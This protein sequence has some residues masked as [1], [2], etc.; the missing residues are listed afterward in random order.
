VLSHFRPL[1]WRLPGAIIW[2]LTP[3]A[4]FQTVTLRQRALAAV[5]AK[6][7]KDGKLPNPFTARQVYHSDWAELSNPADVM[8]ALEVL[9]EAG[10]VELKNPAG[11]RPKVLYYINPKIRRGTPK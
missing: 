6:K 1:N 3:G 10:W 11:G 9:E 7:I 8:N 4:I 5:V 2:K